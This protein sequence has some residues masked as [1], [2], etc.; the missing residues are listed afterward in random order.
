MTS[1]TMDDA[2]TPPTDHAASAPPHPAT[3]PPLPASP[4]PMFYRRPVLLSSH[5]HADWRVR[6]AGVGFAAHSHSVPVVAGEFAAASRSY[7]LVFAGGDYMPMAL[8]G[9]QADSNRFADGNDWKAGAYVPAYVRRYPFV[10]VQ[11][12]EPEGY[13]LAIDA[14]A[15]MVVASGEEGLPLF[16][17]GQPSELTRQA[18]QFCETFTREDRATRQFTAQLAAQGL[19]LERTANITFP[20]GRKASIDGFHVVDTEKFAT[21]SEE[22]IVQWHRNGWLSLVHFHLASLARFTDLMAS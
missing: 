16:E 21:L 14:D 13:A 12:N 2:S 19:L 8:L 1:E 11:M 6:P 18:L 10:F 15:D 4:W 9:L 5:E 7:P 22:V 17:G 3:P 20:D